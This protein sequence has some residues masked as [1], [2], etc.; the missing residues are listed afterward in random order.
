MFGQHRNLRLK[1]ETRTAVEATAAVD[2]LLAEADE[3]LREAMSVQ[4]SAEFAQKVRARIA[5]GRREQAWP[6]WRWAAAA[7]CVLAIGIGWRAM[8]TPGEERLPES[9]RLR[10]GLDVPLADPAPPVREVA[11]VIPVRKNPS[12][13][14][15]R[16]LTTSEPE[17]IVPEE[18]ARAV[19]KLLALVRS[20]RVDEERLTPVASAVAPDALDVLPIDVTAIPAPE[21]ETESAASSSDGRQE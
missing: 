18:N 1:A 13:A 4:P 16:T 19:A 11:P 21:M 20:G 9:T 17:I 10:T 7:A 5:H 8:Q 14:A 2:R 15:N 3:R 12:A 6:V